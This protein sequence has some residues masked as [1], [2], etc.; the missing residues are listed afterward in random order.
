MSGLLTSLGDRQ[1][2]ARAIEANAAELLLTMG[3]AGGGEEYRS[4]HLVYTIGGSPIDY[5]NAVVHANLTPET[6]D[7]A[8]RMIVGKLREK[9]VPGTWHLTE[10]MFPLN[11]AQRLIEAS[12]TDGGFEPCMAVNL[13]ALP[14]NAPVTPGLRVLRAASHE[15]IDT[16]ASTLAQGFGEGEREANWVGEVYKRIG[17]GEES[18]F[19]HYVAW[20]G[21]TPVATASLFLDGSTAGI[22]FVMTAP[23]ARRKGIGAAIT[24]HALREARTMGYHV[25]VLG[26]SAMGE[27]VYRRLGFETFSKMHVYE[28]HGENAEAS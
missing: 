3:R 13:Y 7:A 23:E 27:S 22:Y 10:A 1:V 24:L 4:E 18:P 25:G 12:F 21:D 26:A 2:V 6:A 15:D 9:N 5:H 8:V 17:L 14:E 19:R 16:W 28:W 11:L 20:L